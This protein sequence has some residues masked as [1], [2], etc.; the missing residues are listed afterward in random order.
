MEIDG[1]QQMEISGNQ[2]AP[3][4]G[5]QKAGEILFSF[6]RGSEYISDWDEYMAMKTWADFS[7]PEVDPRIGADLGIRTA[8]APP[9]N[10]PGDEEP[11]TCIPV[12]LEKCGDQ[13]SRTL[14]LEYVGNETSKDK[15]MQ[16]ISVFM[17]SLGSVCGEIEQSGDAFSYTFMRESEKDSILGIL[18]DHEDTLWENF[19]EKV[20]VKI[21]RS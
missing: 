7:P 11:P 19:K 12:P 21:H 10:Q 2:A 18:P 20:G 16:A 5:Q 14:T 17:K 13:A 1:D 15:Q 4:S 3:V 6:N 8:I 9:S